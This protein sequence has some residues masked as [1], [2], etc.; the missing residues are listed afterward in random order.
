MYIFPHYE[1]VLKSPEPLPRLQFLNFVYP[2]R[3]RE[4]IQEG[5]MQKCKNRK[6][7]CQEIEKSKK[8]KAVFKAQHLRII[9]MKSNSFHQLGEDIHKSFSGRTTKRGGGWFKPPN[10][11]ANFFCC[12]MKGKN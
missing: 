8:R 5:K 11:K 12:F 9:Y 1:N 4:E 2:K 10:H 3:G 6:Y 7:S